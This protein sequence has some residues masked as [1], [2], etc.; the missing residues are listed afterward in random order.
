[1]MIEPP[2]V[3]FLTLNRLFPGTEATEKI[4]K[5]YSQKTPLFYND[6]QLLTGRKVCEGD[7]KLSTNLD[8][9]K[10]HELINHPAHIID[11]DGSL[12]P[13]ALIPFC[14][15]GRNKAIGVKHDKFKV[16]VCSGFEKVQRNNQICYEFNPGNVLKNEDIRDAFHM[17]VD[18]NQDKRMRE[19]KVS[20]KNKEEIGRAHV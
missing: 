1:M 15:Y 14:W 3:I 16:P 4:F 11:Q 12:S 7:C 6:L 19:L 17:I 5:I 2:K 18:D 8:L 9:N 10:A 20:D 13:S